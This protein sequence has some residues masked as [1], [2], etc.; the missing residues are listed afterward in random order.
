MSKMWKSEWA[1]KMKNHKHRTPEKVGGKI[2]VAVWRQKV[3]QH[4]SL[5]YM[6]NEEETAKTKSSMLEN[7]NQ[8]VVLCI[9]GGGEGWGVRVKNPYN[10]SM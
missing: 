1:H 2:A 9:Y 4:L 6:S 8:S 7:R 3:P 10:V 5:Y